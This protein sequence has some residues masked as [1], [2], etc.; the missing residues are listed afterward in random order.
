MTDET[1][2]FVVDDDE[3]VRRAVTRLLKLD[4]YRVESYPS[5][6]AI[7]EAGTADSAACLV[8]DLRMPGLNGLELVE[9]LRQRGVSTPAVFITGHADVPTSVQAMKAGA[10]EFLEKPFD[11]KIL[12][13]AVREAVERD[14]TER[15][16]REGLADIESR[17]KALTSREREV[18]NL[19]VQ[20][21]LNKQIA[22]Q[23]GIA[24]KTVKVHRGRVMEK[25]EAGSLAELVRLAGRLGIGDS[26]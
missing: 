21:L 7:L 5:P 6:Q 9:E 12:L 4:G 26:G 22:G 11:D 3:L 20:G 15:I 13:K 16:D 19:V 25:M 8:L 14:R 17:A 10:V 18:M 23:L 2:V 24:E 1:A